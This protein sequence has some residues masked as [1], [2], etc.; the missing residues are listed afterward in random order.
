MAFMKQD[1]VNVAQ[2]F[3]Y[4]LIISGTRGGM[5]RVTAD[6]LSS[7]TSTNAEDIHLI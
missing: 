4:K 1:G 2:D 7:I 5:V 3:T 6:D